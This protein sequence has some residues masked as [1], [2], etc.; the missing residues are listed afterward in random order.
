MTIKEA[1]DD[2]NPDSKQEKTNKTEDL[3]SSY[4]ED[5]LQ[6]YFRAKGGK[7]LLYSIIVICLG[8]GLIG[9][10]FFHQSFLYA[11]L[12]PLIVI[13][14]VSVLYVILKLISFKSPKISKILD[15]ILLIVCCT[16]LIL[17]FLLL[18]IL[19][20]NKFLHFWF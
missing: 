18:I 10:F 5:I 14:F 1:N 16:I 20:L 8:R 11:F 13:G 12:Y 3:I 15:K 17:V 9:T 4:R 6:R 2:I 7:A 19:L